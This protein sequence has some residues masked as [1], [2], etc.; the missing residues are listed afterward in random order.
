MKSGV[1]RTRA[2]PRIGTLRKARIHRA[3]RIRDRGLLTTM[4]QAGAVGGYV[5][6]KALS[7][8]TLQELLDEVRK[9]VAQARADI[10]LVDRTLGSTTAS[11]ASGRNRPAGQPSH[12]G[13]R[14]A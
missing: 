11:T 13:R 4:Y 7:S 10:E 14:S 6:E 1:Q 12:Q 9:R 8:A 2:T 3:Y 5:G